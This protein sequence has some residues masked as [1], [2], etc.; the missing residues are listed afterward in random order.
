MWSFGYKHH[1][2]PRGPSEIGDM[3][4][5]HPVDTNNIEVV[6]F[7]TSTGPPQ[8]ATWNAFHPCICP[9]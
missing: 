4:T 7:K 2:S 5:E 1:A 6:A 9:Q 8:N 3:E